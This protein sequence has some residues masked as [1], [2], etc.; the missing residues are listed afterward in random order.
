MRELKYTDMRN[1]RQRERGRQ[2]E[3]GRDRRER[4]DGKSMSVQN[5]MK[6]TIR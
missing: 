4:E 5:T 3:R 2:M 1:V 6:R